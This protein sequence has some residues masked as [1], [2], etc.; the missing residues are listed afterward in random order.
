MP[1]VE[2]VEAVRELTA[3]FQNS[4]A[5]LL[6][7]FTGLKVSEMK[8]L[9]QALSEAGGDFKVVK[10][11]LSRIAAREAKLEG[12]LPLLEG[13]TAIAF[14]SGDP[15]AAAKG[16]DA[17]SKK[18]PALVVKGGILG[19]SV[20]DAARAS[21]LA[22]V[23]PREVLLGQLA[24]MLQS[25]VQKLAYLLSAPVRELG[26]VLAALREKRETEA[27]A[28]AAE[29]APESA[30]EAAAETAP[31]GAVEAAPEAAAET[32]VETAGTEEAAAEPEAA[33]GASAEAPAESAPEAAAE[34][35]PEAPPQATPEAAAETTSDSGAEGPSEGS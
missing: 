5:A 24:G 8:E 3:R 17:V 22:K 11:T 14:I 34:P 16:L 2:K 23:A 20:L 21:A 25:P 28:P 1:K 31:E 15:V 18:Y 6:A 10:N 33:S 19:G 13:S 30:P 29:A 4:N 26:Y 27:P 12:L 7:E 9:R 32:A 35:A